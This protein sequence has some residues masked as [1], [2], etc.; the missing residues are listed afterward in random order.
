MTGAWQRF[1]YETG[2]PLIRLRGLRVLFFGTLA[3]DMWLLM[4]PRAYRLG[5]G[6]FNVS[7]V[8]WLDPWLPLPTPEVYTVAY[9]LAGFL[10]AGVAFGLRQRWPVVLLFVLYAATFM[11]SQIDGFQHHWF[12][13][14]ALAIACFVPWPA[15]GDPAGD[16]DEPRSSVRSWA[17]RLLVVQLAA[18][19]LFATVAKLDPRW[20][21]GWAL[22]R[23][24]QASW[25]NEVVVDFAALF[26]QER[27]WGFGVAA[28]VVAAAE[29]FIAVG[30]IV[31]RLHL[32]AWI[33]AVVL[34][35]GVEV[36]GLQ[37]RL[38]SGYLLIFCTLLLWPERW[39]EACA[40]GLRRACRPLRRLRWPAR[41]R[42]VA[43]LLG[44]AACAAAGLLQPYPAA[45]WVAASMVAVVVAR[46][47][48]ARGDDA[49]PSR[50]WRRAAVQAAAGAAM[51][52][53]ALPGGAAYEYHRLDGGDMVLRGDL[54]GAIA[55]YERAVAVAPSAP[56][57]ERK[58]AG[59]Y[60]QVGRLHDA[61]RMYEAALRA[62]P[63]DDAS[64]E[65]LA[66]T[67]QRLERAAPAP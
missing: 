26:G 16:D 3:V 21:D 32:A 7:E 55:A 52:A 58:L 24:L 31:R 45:T 61:E 1:W 22:S 57:R 38:F 11:W 50:S 27:Q 8:P 25:V 28:V 10:A 9:L 56:S 46:E 53:I 64:R 19:Y 34:H 62:D 67:R 63:E 65:G 2:T 43:V 20:L 36:A 18:V 30:L 54:E 49:R 15:A 42:P 37:V 5:A 39:V 17:V 33:V 23:Q 13:C 14:L 47:A 60:L 12:L 41:G 6:G 48:L 35:V 40:A 29:L 44:V 66:A 4:M 51:L 59:L